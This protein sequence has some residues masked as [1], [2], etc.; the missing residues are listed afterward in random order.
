MLCVARAAD[1]PGLVGV[2]DSLDSIAKAEFAE[3]V[4][5][6][7]A[8]TSQFP[9]AFRPPAFASR[10]SDC[11]PGIGSSH[12]RPTGPKGRTQ[13]GLPRSARTNCN[14]GGRPL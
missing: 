4:R 8:I 2:D 11:R 6:G 7:P 13:T 1:Q 12:G 3:D 10:S 14:R 5:D 9:A